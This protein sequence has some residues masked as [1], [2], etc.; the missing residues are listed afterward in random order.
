MIVLGEAT[1]TNIETDFGRL[2]LATRPPNK[3]IGADTKGLGGVDVFE[4]QRHL[5]SDEVAL[6]FI[7][8]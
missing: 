8:L 6:V 2:Q 3:R 7:D 1:H 4:P 5:Q